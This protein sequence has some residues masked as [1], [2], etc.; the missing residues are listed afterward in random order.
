MTAGRIGG[1]LRSDLLRA[2]ALVL[3]AL[4]FALALPV[5]VQAQSPAALRTVAVA[6]GVWALVGPLGGPSRDNDA[7][8]AT[9]GVVATPEGTVLIDSGASAQGAR[10]LAAMAERLTGTPVRWV[11][12]TGSQHHRWFGNQALRQ[13]GA[14]VIAHA[15][16]VQTQ[17]TLAGAQAAELQA[18]L[19]DRFEGSVAAHAERVLDG[20][21]TELT[22]GGV[23]IE[24]LDLGDAHFPGDTVVWLAASRIAFAGDLVYVDRLL[25]LAPLSDGASWL[26]AF[27]RLAAL[28]PAQVV[29]GHGSP[30]DVATAQAQ[31]GAYLRF[32]VDG[33]KRHAK[34]MAGVEAAMAELREAP[35]FARLANFEQLHR[36][37]INRAYLRA[38]AG[39]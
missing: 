21:R 13:G 38:E 12:N 28:A 39:D 35:A 30:T 36:P 29:P 7:L 6:P 37:N 20:A 16:T 23:R 8:N 10:R 32:V 19:G 15:R 24:L 33:V 31:T 5:P 4:M 2:V 18:L 22:L 17:R 9:F 26:R 14:Q 3:L 34:E 1:V 27:D 11:I 25:S